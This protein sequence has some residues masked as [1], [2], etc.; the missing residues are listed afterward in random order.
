M[1]DFIIE[2]KNEYME[3]NEI[4]GIYK[5]VDLVVVVFDSSIT[6]INGKETTIINGINKILC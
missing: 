5:Y 4:I 6:S 1:Q 2:N 3:D